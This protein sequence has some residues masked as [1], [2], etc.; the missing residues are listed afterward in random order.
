MKTLCGAIYADE[1]KRG[2]PMQKPCLSEVVFTVDAHT[3]CSKQVIA[4][5]VFP[6]AI[7]LFVI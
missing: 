4:K 2:R 3:S 7:D 5:I 1:A 6:I